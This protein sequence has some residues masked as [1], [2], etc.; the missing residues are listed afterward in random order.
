MGVFITLPAT[1]AA[2]HLSRM[3]SFDWLCIDLQHGDLTSQDISPLISA[4]AHGGATAL[5]RV[6]DK[7]HALI[8]WALDAGAT[9]VVVPTI[10][11]A[12]DAEAAVRA[13]RYP[14]RGTRSVGPFR[15]RIRHGPGYLKEANQHVYCILMVESVGAALRI[16]SILEVDGIDAILVGPGDLKLSMHGMESDDP[17]SHIRRVLSACVR[18]GVP[19]GLFIDAADS[20]Q[21]WRSAGMTVLALGTDVQLLELGARHRL[22]PQE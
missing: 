18:R 7:S 12:E 4:I 2:E 11:S 17:E 20:A 13:T 5:V 9:G 6:P 8:G 3:G 16:D 15:A 21:R 14:P 19:C 1:L 10:E 22:E